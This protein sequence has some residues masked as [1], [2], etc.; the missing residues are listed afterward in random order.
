M[1]LKDIL[2]K[3]FKEHMTEDAIAEIETLFEAKVVEKVNSL[4]EEA[5]TKITDEF[6]EN[7]KQELA[8]FKQELVEQIDA[9]SKLVVDEFKDFGPVVLF[10]DSFLKG[11]T[12]MLKIIQ[13]R[14]KKII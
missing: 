13:E 2:N 5:K 14:R 9:Y 11:W 4:V 8:I 1:K 12:Y 3:H 10:R 7:N 6:V